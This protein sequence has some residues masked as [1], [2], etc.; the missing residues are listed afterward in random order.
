MKNNCHSSF[1]GISIADIPRFQSLYRYFNRK[2][3]GK[4][5]QM[6][7]NTFQATDKNN[8]QKLKSIAEICQKKLEKQEI[9]E[10]NRKNT[11]IV[12]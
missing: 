1:D 4:Q 7:E 2:M 3:I 6:M 12:E 11:K 10:K 8:M 5:Y 9:S